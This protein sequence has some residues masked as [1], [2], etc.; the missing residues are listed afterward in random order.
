MTGGQEIFVT[1]EN[2]RDS[3]L[4]PAST[5]EISLNTHSFLLINN[6]ECSNCIYLIIAV[7]LQLTGISAY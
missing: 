4:V 5:I 1:C 7:N 3:L 6:Y 2:A